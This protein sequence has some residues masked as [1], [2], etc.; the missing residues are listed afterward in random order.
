[1]IGNAEKR[2][3]ELEQKRATFL[4]RA[5]E[6]S[7]LTIPALI[8]ENRDPTATY[9]TPYQGVGARGV[10]NLAAKLLL[11]LIP[12]NMPFF[13]LRIDD[14]TLQDEADGDFLAEVETALS[15]IE[16]L[17]LGEV[18]ATSDRNVIY[19]GLRYLIVGGNTLYHFP[20]SG[21]SRC[22]H[23]D[24][25]VVH[26][27]PS[28]NV[29]E[30]IV[31]ET[32]ALSLLP[33]KVQKR[34]RSVMPTAKTT[35]P[36]D[37]E[38]ITIYTYVRRDDAT[39]F[40]VHQ[41]AKGIVLPDSVGT[42]PVDGC[43]WVPVRFSRIDGSDYGRSYCEDYK[44]DLISLEAFSRA[45]VEGG[46]AL[47]K[48]LFLVNPMGMTSVK[49]LAETPNCGF[50]AGRVDDVSCLQPDKIM[51]LRAAAEIADK[52]E[53]R[54]ASVFLLNQS[55]QRAAE[56]VTAEEIRLIAEDL[57][58]ALG[59]VYSLLAE[60][61]QLPYV[62]CKL[63]RL[64]KQRRM[65]PLPKNVVRPT[66]TTG[67]EA[68]GRS[69]DKA[70][71]LEFAGAGAQLLGPQFQATIRPL[72][73]LQRFAAALGLDTKGLLYSEEDLQAMRQQ[74]QMGEMVNRLGPNTINAFKDVLLKNQDGGVPQNGTL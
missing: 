13:K 63:L 67:M 42:Y 44:G 74:Q 31:R 30:I 16:Q 60:E 45:L 52:I 5:Q 29:I 35:D 51:D 73:F 46:G 70:K 58:T 37:H 57:E 47:A 32:T 6:C 26:R 12:P 34:I 56:R 68:L 27:D 19:E 72:T 49:D 43:P 10:N 2:Y 14:M 17:T 39:T 41:E 53:R 15:K 1:M 61:F 23:F 8:P 18:A 24:Q 9:S 33:P 50:A 69:S 65:P 7:A 66:V 11:A 54:L 48:V 3:N 62:R 59:G 38:P 40:K 25:F 28:G 20:T 55:V 21:P 71:L 22:F 4:Q 36:N 64:Q